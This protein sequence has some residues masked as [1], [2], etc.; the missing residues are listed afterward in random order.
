MYNDEKRVWS[1]K[2]GSRHFFILIIAF[3]CLFIPS[4]N[5]HFVQPSSLEDISELCRYNDIGPRSINNTNIPVLSGISV[6]YGLATGLLLRR[7]RTDLALSSIWLGSC[8]ELLLQS[9]FTPHQTILNLSG[10]RSLFVIEKYSSFVHKFLWSLVLSIADDFH[11]S[12][13]TGNSLKKIYLEGAV[14]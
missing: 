9:L 12:Y 13:P 2:K 3:R 7:Q 14:P 1:S 11:F 5:L 6:L 10:V 4:Q 8:R